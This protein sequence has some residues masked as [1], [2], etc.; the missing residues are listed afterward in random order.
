MFPKFSSRAG[1]ILA[2]CALWLCARSNAVAQ[3]QMSLTFSRHA[4]IVY[5][6]IVATVTITNYAGRDIVL[7]DTPNKPWL[8]MEVTTLDGQLLSPLDPDAPLRSVTVPSG[9]TVKRSLNLTPMYPI[10]DLGEHRVRADLYL[11]EADKYIYSNFVTFDLTSGKTIWR[12]EVGVPGDRGDL[13]EV[14]LLTHRLLDRMLLYV[15]VRA[16]NGNTVYMTEPIG[17]L[18]ATG[19]DPEVMLDRNNT[20]HVLQEAAPGAYLYT[21]INVDGE[22]LNQQAYSRVGASRP[23]LVKSPS[24]SV[25]E[26]G[27]QVQVAPAVAVKGEA[28]SAPVKEP[29][30]SDR[31]KG[32]PQSTDQTR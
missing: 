26:R 3:L 6:P 23:M 17:R 24:G 29:K 22:R 21:V 20:V 25:E 11:P 19:R 10:R 15:R 12:Q 8:N 28:G 1:V 2:A 32:L 14:S 16:V 31:P 27:G 13:R 30:L 5:E 9:Q 18:V 4:Y 7:E